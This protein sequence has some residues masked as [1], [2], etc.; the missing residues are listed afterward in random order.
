MALGVLVALRAA[1][2]WALRS[3]LASQ[4]SEAVHARVEIGDVDLA[5]WRGGVALEDVAVRAADEP[6]GG[7]TEPPLVGWKRF[8]VELAWLPL[9][10]KNI[11]LRSVELDAPRVALD[12]LKSGDFNLMALMPKGSGEEKPSEEKPPEEGAGWGFGIDRFVLR[13]GGLRFRDFMIEGH[14]PVELGL[15]EIEVT[16]VALSPGLYGEPARIRLGIKVDEGRLRLDA[17]LAIREKG[18]AADSDLR[19]SALPLRRAR[20]YIPNVGWSDVRGVLGMGVRHH[21]DSDGE[22]AVRGTVTLDDVTVRVPGHEEP[23]LAWQHLAVRVDPV[24]VPA[25]RARVR[26]VEL[27]GA[28]VLVRPQGGD[29][30]PVLGATP[31]AGAA[32]PPEAPPP[33]PPPTAPA[34]AAKPWRWS[35]DT[36]RVTDSRVRLLGAEAPLDVQVGLEAERLAGEGEAAAPVRLTLQVGEG[37]VAADGNLRVAE[38]GF[39]GSVRID[40]LSLPELV[41]AAGALPPQLLQSGRLGAELK[42]ALGSSAPTRGDVRV[43]GKL[44]LAEP[45]LA[46]ADAQEFLVG[47]QA[48]DVGVEEIVVPGALA[49]APP[50]GAVRPLGVHLGE[51]RLAAPQVQLARAAEG[52]VLPAFTNAPAATPAPAVQE[53]SAAPEAAPP[54]AATPPGI[55]VVIDALRLTQGRVTMVDRTVKPY[56]TGGF[57]PL[58]VEALRVR[59]PELAIGRLRVDATNARGGKLLVTGSLAP[60]GGQIEVNGKEIALQPFNPYATHYSSYSIAKGTLSVTSKA[61]FGKRGYDSSTALT[62]HGFDLGGKE[63][64]S[65]FQEQFGLPLSLALALLTD[66]QGNIKVDIPVEGDEKGARI[67]IGTVAAGALRRALVNALASPLKLFGAVVQGDKVQAAAPPPIAFRPGR[68]ELAPEGVGGVEQLGTFLASRPGIGVT[69][70]AA[71]SPEDARWLAEQAL[72]EELT[73]PQG[74]FGAVRTVGQR[75]ARERI[76]IVLEA[77]SRDETGTLEAEDQEM[78]ERW[79]AERPAVPAATLDA[80]A[81]AR[82]AKVEAVLEEAHGIDPARLARGAPRGEPA[83]GPPAVHFELGAAAALTAR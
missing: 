43:S 32:P 35:V 77:R 56:F 9:F 36:L 1:L 58:E 54:A 41:A 68:A 61:S 53:E 75:G 49:P 57:S 48:I 47:A 67:G 34:P 31:A 73:R 18:L 22:N 24:D 70:T 69:L 81:E 40:R 55:E 5:L 50:A 52:L 16:D 66:V 4:A 28:T 80:L 74:V 83:T 20:V 7:T 30:L 60:T 44:S 15:R 3:L 21:F 8:A 82:T 71:P 46:A 65:L 6:A 51:L 27:G 33:A 78:L 79:L 23:A 38:P 29:L 64:D 13:E 11:V 63:G 17:R 12:R 72:R 59:W 25:Q 19:A 45:R 62:L 37:S 10:R 42:L 2:P 26:S 39:D 14:E 76:R